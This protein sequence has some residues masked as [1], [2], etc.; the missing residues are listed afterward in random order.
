MEVPEVL[1][2]YRERIALQVARMVPSRGHPLYDSVRHQI[3]WSGEGLPELGKCIRPT[4]CLLTCDAVG[5]D[6]AQALPAAAAIE[7]VH[8]FPLVHDDIEDGDELRHHRPTVWAA[9]GRERGMLT[10]AALWNLAYECLSES[11]EQGV[12][13]ERVLSARQLVTE[14]CNEMIEGQH[15]DLS[16]ESQ[17]RVT[18]SDYIE[19][20]A[21]KTGAL[22]SASVRVGALLGGAPQDEIERF[23]V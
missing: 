17:S 9:F 5:G 6:L 19:M 22:V 21:R 4:L 18:L 20:I 3:G 14:A 15:L 7:L 13:A 12:P 11:A 2:R 16:Y 8:N 1:Q 23:G 10:G